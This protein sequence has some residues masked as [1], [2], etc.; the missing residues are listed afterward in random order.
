VSGVA[1]GTAGRGR[2]T[3]WAWPAPGC[4]PG[5]RRP[6][7][8]P[9]PARPTRWPAGTGAGPPLPRRCRSRGR[10]LRT[11]VIDRLLDAL[12]A[13]PGLLAGARHAPGQAPIPASAYNVAAQLLAAETGADQNPPWARVHLS[14]GQW[15]TLR[16][17]RIGISGPASGTDIAVTIEQTSPPER[18]ALFARA[19]GLS[20]RES[21][22]LGHLVTG[23]DT[24]ELARRMFLS[25]TPCRI[26]S[27]RSSRRPA[28]APAGP[29]CPAPSAPDPGH[30][31][32]VSPVPVSPGRVGAGLPRG[33]GR[34]HG[35]RRRQ[36]P[37]WN[38][39]PRTGA[40]PMRARSR[41]WLRGSSS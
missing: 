25:G 17:A 7:P 38:Q 29:C 39:V 12:L 35:G 23:A 9:R 16:P 10:R 6:E 18:V 8:A 27:S 41:Q 21:E 36:R 1:V 19:F 34:A 33:W 13:D 2:A 30:P 5:A 31:V 37:P 32:P 24:R 3:S 26:T 14:D 28:P 4:W 40:G 22:L 20:A 11:G 15:V